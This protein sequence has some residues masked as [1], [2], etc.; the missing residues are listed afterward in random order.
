MQKV[1]ILMPLYNV[2][3]Y[4]KET[5]ESILCQTYRDFL[6]LVIDDCSTDNTIEVVR[7][8]S[9]DRIRIVQNDH[10][11]GLA[12]NLNK[13]L[14]LVRTD[15][16][17]RF[18]GD[19]IAEPTWLEKEVTFLDE[20]P[21]YGICSTCF[22][23]F[24]TRDSRVNYVENHEDIKAS[25][26]FGC[27]VIVPTFRMSLYRVHQLKYDPTTFPA[28]DYDFWTRCM[29]VT[30]IHNIQEVLFHYRMH[31]TQISTSRRA[32]QIEQT[33]G[34]RTRVLK[35]L[36]PDLSEENVRFFIETFSEKNITTKQELGEMLA[37]SSK[38]L[39]ANRKAGH[40]D[41]ISLG[42]VLNGHIEGRLYA[43]ILEMFFGE[44]YSP[45]RYC[46]YLSSG[47]AFKMSSRLEK[48]LIF[49][50]L[51]FRAR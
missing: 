27:Q 8:F 13:G 22:K 3:L 44:R 35:W 46:K 24:G 51:L 4:I 17:A 29:R 31:A 2:G 11:L 20:H 39:A 36:A 43:G 5:L 18:D 25:M 49:K 41:P 23:W 14:S 50:S 6:L 42:K 7:S 9:D 40:F 12:E 30:K 10:N 21:E 38:L 32:A 28:E 33:R 34:V 16:V 19:D 1:T 45:I 37:F 26:L 48:K 47:L 15:Y